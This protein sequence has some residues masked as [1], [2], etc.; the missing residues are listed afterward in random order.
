MAWMNISRR[1]ISASASRLAAA[2]ALALIAPVAASAQAPAPAAQTAPALLA[3]F[4]GQWE[5]EVAYR[6]VLNGQMQTVGATMKGSM[7][8]NRAILDILL[9]DGKGRLVRQPLAISVDAPSRSFTRDP[10]DEAIT[11]RIV[12]GNLSPTALEDVALVLE[13]RGSEQAVPMDVRET[14]SITGDKMVWRREM[15]P[16]GGTYGF[17]SEYRFTRKP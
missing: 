1:N 7:Q 10:G 15:K 11:F 12:E 4:L 17:R 3:R 16:D 9:D 8:G 6:N 2:A 13:G 14:I 5:G